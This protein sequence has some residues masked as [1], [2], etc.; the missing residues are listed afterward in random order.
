M[1]SSFHVKQ[2]LGCGTRK[3]E[4]LPRQRPGGVTARCCRRADEA[5][6]LSDR[7]RRPG[8]TTVRRHRPGARSSWRAPPTRPEGPQWCRAWQRRPRGSYGLLLGRDRTGR[9]VSAV[10]HACHG[11]ARPPMAVPARH[12]NPSFRALA[13]AVDAFRRGGRR[14]VGTCV[15][16][17]VRREP[18]AGTRRREWLCGGGSA[19]LP[20]LVS[21]IGCST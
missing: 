17:S 19:V 16:C 3:Q 12:P 5:R 7:G 15:S 11:P 13:R 1:S 9:A 8:G 10:L 6:G 20:S 14:V 18:V 4:W 21:D 2:R